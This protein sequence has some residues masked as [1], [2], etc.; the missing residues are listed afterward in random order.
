MSGKP[1]P[2]PLTTARLESAA[3]LALY[4]F[5]V[6]MSGFVIQGAFTGGPNWHNIVAG[7]LITAG[8]AF[9]SKFVVIQNSGAF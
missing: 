8:L 5:C 9:A 1:N 4:T 2:N 7:S 6:S 3:M